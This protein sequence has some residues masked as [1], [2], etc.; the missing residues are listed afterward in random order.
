MGRGILTE[1]DLNSLAS[2]R[3]VASVGKTKITYTEEFKL[4]FLKEY[5]SGKKP[6]RIFKE[7]GFDVAVLGSKRIERCS[8]RW[9]EANAAG[10]LGKK[11]EQND[12][13][14]HYNNENEIMMLMR[15]IKQQDAEIESLKE[16]LKTLQGEKEK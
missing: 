3:Y 4:H 2:N 13:Y 16:Q 15:K 9:R 5:F 10:S 14:D 12:F 6:M 8:A 11:Y 7:A 1:A